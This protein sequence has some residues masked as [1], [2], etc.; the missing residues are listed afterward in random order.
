VRRKLTRAKRRN[1]KEAEVDETH[2]ETI[3]RKIVPAVL[4]EGEDSDGKSILIMDKI[5]ANPGDTIHWELGNREM[6]IWFPNSGV[7]FAP[8]LAVKHRGAIEATIP[9]GMIVSKPVV[10]EYCIFCHDTNEFVTGGSHPKIEIP[11]G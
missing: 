1:P 4:R 7:F 3:T 10:Y 6:S 11:G 9:S 8:V 2:V 5:Y